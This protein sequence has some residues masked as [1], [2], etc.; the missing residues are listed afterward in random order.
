MWLK[1]AQSYVDIVDKSG[2]W[3][4]TVHTLPYFEHGSSED[5]NDVTSYPIDHVI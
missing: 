2:K 1:M 4:I 3:K 5:R